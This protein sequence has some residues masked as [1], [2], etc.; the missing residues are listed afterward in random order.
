MIVMLH[1]LKELG[2][3]AVAVVTGWVS[4]LLLQATTAAPAEP[5][6]YEHPAVISAF[7]TSVI[8]F[9]IKYYERR[10]ASEDEEEDRR[11]HLT[12]KMADLT[13]AGWQ[14][15]L[16]EV[17]EL[18][19]QQIEFLQSQLLI[20]EVEGYRDR[21]IKHVVFN[22]LQRNHGRIRELEVTIAGCGGCGQGL[23]K[24]EFKYQEEL[25]AS[26]EEKVD[27]YRRNLRRNAQAVS[28]APDTNKR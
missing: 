9:G 5:S 18:H 4:T 17:K 22:E 3:G 19:K 27:E 26:V 16:Q 15:Y 13:Q 28:G 25:I 1:G 20:Y 23:T 8:L 2:I 24:F 10:T 14:V 7:I 12:D 11:Q 21:Q 6:W